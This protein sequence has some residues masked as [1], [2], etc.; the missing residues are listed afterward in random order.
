MGG[1]GRP[2]PERRTR[3][4]AC[5]VSS[6][7]SSGSRPTTL[8]SQ[9]DSM[10]QSPLKPAVVALDVS[11]REPARDPAGSAGLPRR[12]RRRS[13][14]CA[15]YP[16]GESRR[17]APRLRRRGRRGRA[18]TSLEQRR[19][20]KPGDLDRPRRRRAGV[21]VGAARPAR[22][23]RRCRST[24][25]GQQVG[26]PVDVEPG[27]VGDNVYLTIDSKV[28]TVGGE[29]ARAG[30]PR[31]ADIQNR[32]RTSQRTA[33]R[34]S[35]RRPARW[36]CS[37]RTTARSSRW[38]AIPT[39]PLNAGSAA[40]ARR[41][42]DAHHE[43]VQRTTRCSTGPPQGQYAPGSTFKLVTSLAMTQYG[44][45]G[46]GD[47]YVDNGHVELGGTDLRR[48]PATTVFGP[49]N[50]AEALTV[51]SDTYFYTVGD[52]FW[53]IWKHG[54]K[55]ARARA[56]RPR[57]G[58]LGFGEPTGIE[59]DEP[60]GRVPD[61]TWKADFAHANYKTRR[62]RKPTR[63]GTRATTSSPRSARATDSSRRC[64]SPNAYAAFANGGTLVAAARRGEGHR[65]ER[66]SRR[67]DTAEGDPARSRSTRRRAPRC[68]PASRARSRTR[69]APRTPRSRASPRPGPR[70]GQDRHRRRS[71]SKGDT[72][73]FAALFG[74]PPDNPQ[75]VVVGGRRAGRLRRADRG[76]DRAPDHR[77][78]ERSAGAARRGH[79][80]GPRLMAQRRDPRPDGHRP[81]VEGRGRSRDVRQRPD[82]RSRHADLVLLRSRSRSARSAC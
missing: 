48:T 64:S 69:R 13:S 60:A 5:S 4:S 59:V 16:H 50:L 9:Y 35:R 49:V 77:D 41:D 28:Q 78:D 27:T 66:R 14:P 62:T 1:H 11:Q 43:P 44:I 39:Y 75:Y 40:S 47:Y 57:R 53:D 56:S 7:S 65:P 10:R 79:G 20:T 2:Q 58:E 19:A 81:G 54:D 12:A 8:E 22:G 38:R 76:A 17:A 34:R 63:S 32:T 70:R 31:G 24:R 37:T 82:D 15:T 45:R 52:D 72:S 74:R 18:W 61:P 80:A 73:L 36:S 23:A 42:Y 29:R 67:A 6:P 26:P 33:S 51:S 3:A 68:W 30:H 21:R 46:V 71:P 25:T 55:A